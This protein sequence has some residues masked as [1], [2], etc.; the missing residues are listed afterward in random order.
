MKQYV[1]QVWLLLT[2]S[3][4]AFTAKAQPSK[5]DSILK[6]HF[7]NAGG[8]E[9]WKK[10]NSYILTQSAGQ[11]SF[12]PRS[13]T[14]YAKEDEIKE[15]P[16]VT[17]YQYP[18]NYRIEMFTDSEFDRT[19]DDKLTAVFLMTAHESRGYNLFNGSDPGPGIKF[20]DNIH[21][22]VLNS[23]PFSGLGPTHFI[24]LKMAEAE[25]QYNGF[26]EVYGKNCYQLVLYDKKFNSTVNLYMDAKTYLVHA[27]SSR[28]Y[29]QFYKIY[30][31]YQLKDGL[32]IPYT[33]TGYKEGKVI[34][35]FK[36]LAVK[37][38]EEFDEAIFLRR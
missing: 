34:E 38:N 14:D 13:I 4:L 18:D 3:L 11:V 12:S 35:R 33:F 20:P 22:G 25:I 28:E 36:T 9:A 17:Y 24:L 1:T 29:P 30:A 27:V 31:D 7:D 8:I 10:I 19:T 32:M 5:A 23:Q 2:L 21:Q 15:H 6:L 26:V 16:T 37:I